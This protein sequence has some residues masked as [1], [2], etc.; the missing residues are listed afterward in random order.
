MPEIQDFKRL[1][2]TQERVF[3]FDLYLKKSLYG[4]FRSFISNH[5]LEDES[6][7][8]PLSPRLPICTMMAMKIANLAEMSTKYTANSQMDNERRIRNK[9]EF[10]DFVLI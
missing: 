9:D 1:W 10:L 5:D 4:D 8:K 3:P 2:V 6:Q 7:I